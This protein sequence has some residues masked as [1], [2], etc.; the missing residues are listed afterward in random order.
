MLGKRVFGNQFFK[1][2]WLCA[3]AGS[4]GRRSADFNPVLS[5]KHGR[6]PQIDFTP[7][8]YSVCGPL[9]SFVVHTNTPGNGQ[10]P[11]G[12]FFLGHFPATRVRRDTT[13]SASAA[14]NEGESTN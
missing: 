8:T 1:I 7:Y 4:A 13:K 9:T 11:S 12:H 14:L 2:F 10:F 3:F 6:A 5:G